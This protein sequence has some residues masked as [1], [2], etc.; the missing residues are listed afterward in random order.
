MKPLLQ[1]TTGKKFRERVCQK[2][3]DEIDSGSHPSGALQEHDHFK[4]GLGSDMDQE[5]DASRVNSASKLISHES[6]SKKR[7]LLS[8][9]PLNKSSAPSRSPTTSCTRYGG[10]E[11]DGG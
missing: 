4:S 1:S 10:E 5:N 8:P 3:E 7:V 6:V 9:K 2:C 11:N